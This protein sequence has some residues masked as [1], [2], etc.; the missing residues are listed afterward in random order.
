ME[1][2]EKIKEELGAAE[3]IYR[4]IVEYEKYDAGAAYR[5]TARRISGME[6]RSRAAMYFQRV[7]AALFLPVLLGTA[8]LAWLYSEQRREIVDNVPYY[9]VK[10][11][12]GLIS[13]ISLPDGTQVWLNTESSL[14]Y[15]ARFS[16]AERLVELEGEAYFAV[17]ADA[18]H[19]FT[20]AVGKAVR[21]SAHGT[22]FNVSSTEREMS[23]E[24]TLESGSIDVSLGNRSLKLH[25]N[26]MATVDLTIGTLVS[27]NINAWEKTAWKDGRLIFRNAGMEEVA[28][29]LSKKY[30]VD[31]QFASADVLRHKF[32]ASFTTESITQILDYMKLA[33]PID[34]S[35][36][37]PRQLDDYSYARRIIIIKSRKEVTKAKL[38]RK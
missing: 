28:H 16:S 12:P 4:K 30:N 15:P 36:S 33:A 8:A 29:K 6:W 19:P 13:Q 20:V 9:S 31:I 25:P 38:I 27:R 7:A 3:A 21:V 14:R 34:W 26:Q 35:Y 5:K 1:E 22:R 17:E 18:E 11:A 10:S 37:E 32:W 2:H 24:A 23:V